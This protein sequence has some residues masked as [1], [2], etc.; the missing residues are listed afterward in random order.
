M[1]FRRKFVRRRRPFRRPAFRRR[2]VVRRPRFVRR[3]RP[4]GSIVHVK[5]TVKLATVAV[6]TAA[7]N[8]GYSFSVGTFFSSSASITNSFQQF[9][10]NKVV[11]KAVPIVDTSTGLT[12]STIFPRIADVVDFT[13]NTPE[14]FDSLL[15]HGNHRI[16]LG[17][18]PFMRKF[19]PCA[20]GDVQNTGSATV[21][22][23]Q[24]QFKKW[25]DMDATG[26]ASIG[27]HGYKIATEPST[28][29][30]NRY[31]LYLYATGYFSFRL[32]RLQ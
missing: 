8:S 27:F 22:G 4:A 23:V 20:A 13:D 31:A 15:A 17:N 26:S 10:F 2:S 29:S 25:Y 7:N 3:R 21:V 6:T 11:V 18:R 12:L 5:K 28:S 14:T 16:H 1:A 30:D 24:S 19:T 9:R 32:P